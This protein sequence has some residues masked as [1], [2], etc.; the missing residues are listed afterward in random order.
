M[1]PKSGPQLIWSDYAE[2]SEQWIQAQ[3]IFADVASEVAANAADASAS[4]YRRAVHMFE[5]GG[6]G[7]REIDQVVGP[8]RGRYSPGDSSPASSFDENCLVDLWISSERLAFI[9]LTAGPFTWGPVVGGEGLR[10]H[11]S[12]P[13]VS[14]MLEDYYY[15]IEDSPTGDDP[16]QPSG[17]AAVESLG[18]FVSQ[19]EGELTLLK[20]Q[21]QRHCAPAVPPSPNTGGRGAAGDLSGRGT[22]RQ[23]QANHPLKDS[24]ASRPD[25]CQEMKR[26]HDRLTEVITRAKTGGKAKK[27]N[28][29][30]LLDELKKDETA[31]PIFTRDDLGASETSYTVDRALSKLA[32]VMST[33]LR[34][35]VTPLTAE[36][37]T[38]PATYAERVAFQI[39]SVTEHSISDDGGSASPSIDIDMF[40]EEML[41]LKLPSQEFS[42][43]FS[44]L[45]LVDDPTLAVAFALSL[46]VESVERHRVNG[47][48]AI[49]EIQYLDSAHLVH[50]LSHR[51]GQGAK[52]SSDSQTRTIPVFVF[53][54]DSNDPVFIDQEE[55]ATALDGMVIAVE[56]NHSHWETRL[57]CNSKPIFKDLRYGLKATLAATA[58]ALGGLLPLHNSHVDAR[59]LSSGLNS[60]GTVDAARDMYV[61]GL[62]PERAK[63]PTENWLWSVGDSPLCETSK[64]TVSTAKFIP[65][66][67]FAQTGQMPCALKLLCRNLRGRSGTAST[68]TIWLLDFIKALKS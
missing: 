26:R 31:T 64:R 19:L 48:S 32:A 39:Y 63:V 4:I 27:P 47:E 52:R 46:H 10:S 40:K 67:N 29:N 24:F 53:T 65:R 23:R 18:E 20:L 11:S 22:F 38:S 33:T 61:T 17:G 13:A 59:V 50:Q 16:L 41:K 43:A 51:K 45:S 68:G 15:P 12:L 28:V 62:L 42:F 6:D 49:V 1:N 60:V 44:K 9:D 14:E 30:D 25:I 34:Q 55:T 35:L 8:A 66:S 57:M 36:W 58:K 5:D 56:S 7:K 21:V 3:T 37:A 54:L 2:K